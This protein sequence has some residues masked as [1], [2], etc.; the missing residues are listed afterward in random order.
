MVNWQ[1]RAEQERRLQMRN[2]APKTTTEEKKE[3]IDPA[4]S[5]FE[6]PPL[7][8]AEILQDLNKHSKYWGGLGKVITSRGGPSR[9]S[10]ISIK[11]MG[12]ANSYIDIGLTSVSERKE[13]KF[14]EVGEISGPRLREVYGWHDVILYSQKYLICE[15]RKIEGPSVDI[16][17][18]EEGD[19]M[20]P[21]KN[22]REDSR[23]TDVDTFRIRVY[24]DSS[25]AITKKYLNN[26]IALSHEFVFDSFYLESNFGIQVSFP[27]KNFDKLALNKFLTKIFVISLAARDGK[28]TVPEIVEESERKRISVQREVELYNVQQKQE[29]EKNKGSFKRLFKK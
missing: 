2:S 16:E 9:N 15:P 8:I 19:F 20:K 14:L 6:T 25:A 11:L 7:A 17:F 13:G 21:S 10:L 3:Y 4:F 29:Y 23:R 27:A 18:Y 26:P 5:V 12:E 22:T 28:A 1:E 24:D